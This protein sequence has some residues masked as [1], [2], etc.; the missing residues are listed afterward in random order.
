MR[1]SD[2]LL[3]NNYLN[4]MNKIKEKMSQLNQ[5]ISTGKKLH[6][7]SD[8]PSGMAKVISLNNRISQSDTYVNNIQ[9]SRTFVQESI[10]SMESIQQQISGLMGTLTEV[11]DATKT[12][13]LKAYGDK[14]DSILET[15]LASANNEFEGKYLFGGTDFSDK[16]YAYTSDDKS[17]KVN[18]NDVSSKQVV[19]LSANSEQKINT[20]GTEL[21]GTIISQAGTLDSATAVGGTIPTQTTIYNAE[22]NQYTLD[23]SYTKSAANKYNLTYTITDQGGTQVYDNSSSPIEVTFDASTGKLLTVGGS[24]T[25]TVQI[26]SP[27]DKIDFTLNL[28]DLKEGS[29][30]SVT[31]SANQDRDIF[32][33]LISIRDALKSGTIPLDS[34][35]QAVGKF[36]NHILD[37]LAEAGNVVNQLDNTEELLGNQKTLLQNLASKE[38]DV[39]VAQAILEMQNQDYLLQLSYKMSSMILPKSLVDY[40]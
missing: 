27:A 25:G 30:T 8:S 26:K 31:N 35:I 7:P 38:D 19:K 18:V 22:G 28:R 11:D 3:S 5:D 20:T 36:N 10:G 12:E 29:T 1:I 4:S 39:D 23:M 14:L 32:N 2:S 13:S 21:F 16:P 15:V 37:K 17:I 40:I 24:D 33:V 9:L 34:D 6:A